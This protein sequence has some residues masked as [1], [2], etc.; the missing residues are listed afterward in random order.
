MVAIC[1]RVIDVAV[2]VGT[3]A[4]CTNSYKYCLKVL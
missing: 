3:I 2:K 4:S 1:E